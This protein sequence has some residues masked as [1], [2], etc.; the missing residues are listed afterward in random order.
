MFECCRSKGEVVEEWEEISPSKKYLIGNESL[1][2]PRLSCIREYDKKCK[3]KLLYG[4]LECKE[5]QFAML[6]YQEVRL[7]LAITQ[8]WYKH[9][10]TDLDKDKLL[11]AFLLSLMELYF[12]GHNSSLTSKELSCFKSI[13]FI[14]AFNQLLV[15][16]KDVDNLNRALLEP[17]SLIKPSQFFSALSVYN[18]LN[19]IMKAGWHKVVDQSGVCKRTF[20]MMYS[21]IRQY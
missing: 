17:I 8:Y 18:T 1:D 6:E 11:Q 4:V 3:I 13:P 20:Y 15:L 2:L 14:D 12:L 9:C 5:N 10:N 16:Y 19:N 7:L 21:V